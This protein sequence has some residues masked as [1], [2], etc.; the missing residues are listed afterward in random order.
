M[1]R[2]PAFCLLLVSGVLLAPLGGGQPARSQAAAGLSD[3][4]RQLAAGKYEDALALAR[5]TLRTGEHLG[6]R[7]LMMRALVATG[8]REEAALVAEV[9]VGRHPSRLRSLLLA[10]DAFRDRGDETRAAAVLQQLRI[11]VRTPGASIDDADELVAAGEAALL[12]GDEPKTV[13][14]TYF[15]EALKRDPRCKSAFVAGGSLALAK[16][17]DRLAAGWFE[18]GLAKLGAD[19]DLYAGLARA[20]YHG[21][22]EQMTAALDAALHLNARHSG[23]LLL[24]AEHQIDAEDHAGADKTLAQVLQIDPRS[25]PA[26]AFRAVLAHLRHDPGAEAQARQRALSPWGKNPAVDVLIGRKLSQNYRFVE[27]AAYQRRALALQPGYLPATAQLAQDLLRL[28]KTKDNNDG[29][30]LAEQVHRRDGYDVAAYNLVTLRGHLDKFATRN[31]KGFL[32]R[33]DPHEARIYGDEV[34]GLLDEASGK[35]DG[36]YGF[37]RPTP[38]TVEIFPDQADFAVR[39]FGMPG[40]SGYLGVCF[41]ALITMNSPA[42]TGAVPISWRSVLW[43]EYAHVVTLGLTGN[44]IPRW[45]SEGISVHEELARDANWGQRMTPRYRQMILD[46]ELVPVGKLSSAFVAPKSPEHVMFAYY[47]SALAVEYLVQRHG[48]AALRAILADLARG[49]AINDALAARAAPLA[50]LEPGFAAFAR[51]RAA[52]GGAG[53]RF[54]RSPMPPCCATKV[55]RRCPGS[56]SNTPT[57]CR[58]CCCWRGGTWT[59]GPGRRRNRCWN[60]HWRWRRISAGPIHP[61]SGWPRCCANKGARRTS[62]G[63][64]RR[65]RRWPRMR[66]RLTGAWSSWPSKAATCPRW[67]ATPSGCSRSIPCW[68][69]AGARAVGR[70]RRRAPRTIGRRSRRWRRRSRPMKSY[71][72]CSP[73]IRLTRGFAWPSCCWGATGARPNATCSMPWPRRRAGWPGTACCCSWRAGRRKAAHHEAIA[74]AGSAGGGAG[75]GRR[76]VC[77]VG[78]GRGR[79]AGSGR[80]A[81]VGGGRRAPGRR[82]H[83]R[84]AQVSVGRARPRAARRLGARLA[85]RLSGQ[86]LRTCPTGCSS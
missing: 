32:L 6:W 3:A 58:A 66:S 68:R 44:R 47:Q 38:V 56:S 7:T 18:R 4:E 33:M 82:V 28:G 25:P 15:D 16:N 19:A 80:G 73:R 12:A 37:T 64:S 69:R 40:G 70:E 78:L 50:M 60:G 20:H 24:R 29:W 43:H 5:A 74:L 39:T 77:A 84:A 62:G 79:S 2:G 72:C 36:K 57:T 53:G 67:G 59:P 49:V 10:H 45:L 86:R 1:R 9:L 54:R 11:V 85:H 48:L 71:C 22:R 76:G 17:D 55:A 26:W 42:G 41:G 21:D 81:A 52:G 30:G 14:A 61:I 65:W 31:H 83:L 27:G 13:L 8:Q 75:R 46:G 63:C 51:Q 35:L 23:A 34:L